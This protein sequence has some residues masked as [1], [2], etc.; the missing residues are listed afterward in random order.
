MCRPQITQR[1]KA[2]RTSLDGE[3]DDRLVCGEIGET[4]ATLAS[5]ACCCLLAR[6]RNEVLSAI[7]KFNE[8]K[9][10]ARKRDIN[11]C[12]QQVGGSLR[13]KHRYI[14]ADAFLFQH[15]MTEIFNGM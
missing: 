3:I 1:L 2:Q 10:P 5:Q 14:G 6:N 7:E 15:L 11:K 12:Q 4:E 13:E 9:I 8:I